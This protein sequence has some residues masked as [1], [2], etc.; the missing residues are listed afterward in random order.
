MLMRLIVLGRTAV[1]K[2]AGDILFIVW[3]EQMAKW[4]CVA[5]YELEEGREKT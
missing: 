3:E 5:D 2:Q 4:A 1:F